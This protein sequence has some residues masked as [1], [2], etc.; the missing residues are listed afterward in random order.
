MN[1][2]QLVNSERDVT[3]LIRVYRQAVHA[4]PDEAETILKDHPLLRHAVAV[5]RDSMARD[6]E[7]GR[8]MERL[9]VEGLS[10][11][12][13]AVVARKAGGLQAAGNDAAL[14]PQ[15]DT[16]AGVPAG[17]QSGTGPQPLDFARVIHSVD[18][19]R[20]LVAAYRLALHGGESVAQQIY[21]QYPELQPIVDRTLVYADGQHDGSLAQWE[22]VGV[23]ALVE[24]GLR[25][26][27]QKGITP[28]AGPPLAPE[29]ER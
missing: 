21:R 5:T 28:F 14:L 18:D 12:G 15:S 16:L 7:G 29:P 26:L 13:M 25:T 24:R 22:E 27:E 1:F 4:P 3:D 17:P 9:A 10:E 11:G 23:E 2:D 6:S 20:Q 8:E 19:I